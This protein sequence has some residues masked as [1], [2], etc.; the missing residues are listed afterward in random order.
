MGVPP[1]RPPGPSSPTQGTMLPQFRMTVWWTPEPRCSPLPS[2]FTLSSCRFLSLSMST[3]ICNSSLSASQ[4][5]SDSRT[6]S[7]SSPNAFKLSSA[8]HARDSALSWATSVARQIVH[9][10]SYFDFAAQIA[11]LKMRFGKKTQKVGFGEQI[12]ELHTWWNP[13]LS[14]YDNSALVSSASSSSSIIFELAINS[15]KLDCSVTISASQSANLGIIG[16]QDKLFTFHHTYIIRQQRKELGL[17]RKENVFRNCSRRV[18]RAQITSY[19]LWIGRHWVM[20]K[21]FI[22]I[23]FCF[24]SAR[25]IQYIYIIC[26]TFTTLLFQ[27]NKLEVLRISLWLSSIFRIIFFLS[28]L[29]LCERAVMDMF[30]NHINAWW[31][32]R[33]GSWVSEEE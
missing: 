14:I 31:V 9:S 4:N 26:S 12:P 28:C 16:A 17:L 23:I 22:I 20:L 3:S 21:C 13:V 2:P 27:N 11:P 25:V 19:I 1:D 5:A 24:V 8:W 15:S 18:D 30:G 6:A 33:E 29:S 7:H 10:S 32:Y